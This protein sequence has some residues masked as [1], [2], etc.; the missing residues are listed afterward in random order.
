VGLPLDPSTYPRPTSIEPSTVVH[1]IS[2]SPDGTRIAFGTDPYGEPTIEVVSA[3][4]GTVRTTIAGLFPAW[5]PTGDR[6]AFSR[7][8]GKDG[9][10]L[11]VVDATG[12][13]E[14]AIT[15]GRSTDLLP[16]WS[17]DGRFLAYASDGG[18]RPGQLEIWVVHPDGT[19]GKRLTEGATEYASSLG[20]GP[21]WSPDGTKLLYLN[22]MFGGGAVD[23]W[24]GV[25]GVDG[26]DQHT[27]TDVESRSPAWQP[28]LGSVSL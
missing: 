1:S 10:G 20:I 24:V 15:E 16:S 17:P 22:K 12:E 9:T 23:L 7:R 27:V 3:A 21:A 26:S 25:V 11:F 6:I 18:G 19:E 14:E 8:T 13:G 2:W 5:S 4:D 28:I